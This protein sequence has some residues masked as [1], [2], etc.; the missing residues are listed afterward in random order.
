MGGN[1]CL[2]SMTVQ[3]VINIDEA[4]F[5]KIYKLSCDIVFPLHFQYTMKADYPPL[6]FLGGCEGTAL[7]AVLVLVS[8]SSQMA[9]P[10]GIQS[11]QNR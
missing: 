2:Q 6:R 9:S 7:Q 1:D 11:S 4:K 5:R 8:H 10:F 3:W